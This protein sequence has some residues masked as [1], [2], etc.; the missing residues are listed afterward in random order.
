MDTQQRKQEIQ[1]RLTLS[2]YPTRST[3][4]FNTENDHNPLVLA[5][6]TSCR[7]NGKHDDIQQTPDGHIQS[8]HNCE[9]CNGTGV[10]ADIEPCFDNNNDPIRVNPQPDGWLQCPHCGWRFTITDQNAFT[11]LRHKRCGQKL[12]VTTDSE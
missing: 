4:V 11:G 3:A 12:L 2:Q 10:T 6:C 9:Q 8:L 7:G 1:R 5:A